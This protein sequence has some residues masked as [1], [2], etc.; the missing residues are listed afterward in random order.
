MLVLWFSHV[1]ENVK[2]LK[3]EQRSIISPFTY[4]YFAEVDKSAL[5]DRLILM[6]TCFVFFFFLLFHR[7][8]KLSF[9]PAQLGHIN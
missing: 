6:I 4:K 3:S 7:C 8:Y 5:S 9:S 1:D 2:C